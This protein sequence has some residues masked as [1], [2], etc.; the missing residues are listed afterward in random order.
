MADDFRRNLGSIQI[1]EK[2]RTTHGYPLEQYNW[3]PPPD[4]L[5]NFPGGFTLAMDCVTAAGGMRLFTPYPNDV[6]WVLQASLGGFAVYNRA[7]RLDAEE[8]Y[9]HHASRLFFAKTRRFQE[10][11]ARDFENPLYLQVEN[12]LIGAFGKAHILPDDLGL[13][14]SQEGKPWNVADLLEN[15]RANLPPEVSIS[16]ANMI[17]YG[18]LTAAS[19]NPIDPESLSQSEANALVRSAIFYSD[20]DQQTVSSETVDIVQQRLW[21]KVHDKADATSEKFYQWFHDDNANLIHSIEKQ[22][23]GGGEIDRDLVRQSFVEI[24]WRSFQYVAV[25]VQVQMLAFAESLPTPLTP[26]ERVP[27]ETF[28][29]RKPF[30]GGLSF[31]LLRDQLPFLQVAIRPILCEPKNPSHVGAFLR[32]LRYYGEMSASRRAADRLQKRQLPPT[33]ELNDATM[34]I[35]H[36]TETE[37]HANDA[38]VAIG[39]LANTLRREREICCD[40]PADGDWVIDRNTEADD[41]PVVIN[42]LCSACGKCGLFS[43]LRAEFA[44]RAVEFGISGN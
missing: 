9:S 34:T 16:P 19:R 21:T 35:T 11:Q 29:Y 37:F 43:I 4:V 39:A 23:K 20:P 17:R 15:G 6:D 44:R 38:H 12:S 22:K 32:L 3:S 28:Y 10:F 7:G 14:A 41:D 13:N 8:R 25:G 33:I 27:F 5:G 18:L 31:L 30:L 24:G 36:V 40:C 1:V 42:L 26:E 2:G